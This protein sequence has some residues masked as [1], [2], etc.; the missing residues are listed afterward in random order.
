M[1]GLLVQD[2]RTR[3][4]DNHQNST[5][6]LVIIG[7]KQQCSTLERLSPTPYLDS[8][9]VIQG[10]EGKQNFGSIRKS[11]KPEDPLQV[12]YWPRGETVEKH[13]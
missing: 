12:N 5:R 7:S 1:C 4:S 13:H 6:F 8:Q 2:Q 3:A 11:Q 10:Q 9:L